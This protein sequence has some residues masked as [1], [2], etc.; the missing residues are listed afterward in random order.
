VVGWGSDEFG[1]C[2]DCPTLGSDSREA[3]GSR[4][5]AELPVAAETAAL[6]IDHLAFE[7]AHG[8]A[9]LSQGRTSGDPQGAP[10]R[11]WI[12]VWGDVS[13]GVDEI[14]A[15]LRGTVG[16]ESVAAGAHHCVALD[17][18][19]LV[20][21][22]GDDRAGQCTPPVQTLRAQSI[23][24]GGDVTMAV[25]RTGTLLAWGDNEFGQCAPPARLNS[26]TALDV[27]GRHVAAITRSGT[28][29]CWGDDTHGQASS[30]PDS[31]RAMAIAA[32]GRH[33]LALLEGGRVVAFGSNEEGQCEVPLLPADVYPVAI[34]AGAEHSLI[35]GSDGAVRACGA[36]AGGA[37]EVPEELRAA[38][39]SWC[40]VLEHAP[41]PSVV[42]DE[43]LRSAIVATGHA[44]RV[45]ENAS[46]IEMLLVPPGAFQMGCIQPSTNFGCNSSEQPVHTVTLTNAFYIGRYEVTQAQWQARMGN[47]PSYFR[48]GNGFPN[49]ANR[50]VEQV[51]WNTIQGF[52]SATG[53]RLP[54]EA[55]WE[56]ACRAGTTTPFHSGPGFPSGTTDDTL[57]GQIAWFNCNDG[58]N[59]KFVG[60]KAANALGLHDILG[61]VWE[62]CGDCY[63]D[64]TSAPQ[65]NPTSPG[66]GSSRVLRGGSWSI[67][68]NYACSSIRNAG[69]PGYKSGTVGFRVARTLR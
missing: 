15:D 19:G 63:S 18:S 10:R 16:V 17:H 34:A 21:C 13:L 12:S 20:Y 5:A 65:T 46:G 25:T 49:S 52:L 11:S 3:A 27:G 31:G 47:N 41:D 57:V 14:P 29:V 45:R 40:T 7:G 61:N 67:N 35:L 28:I 6:R 58:C 38:P 1:E 48:E 24:A 59:T 56:Y 26:I 66:S 36:Q 64:Y 68:A 43:S 44:W 22:W 30:A 9:V 39:W 23:A 55:E 51:S 8:V 69:A 62:W 2:T 54:T 53:L 50:P 4:D 60:G 37:C 32:G 42:T 33:T